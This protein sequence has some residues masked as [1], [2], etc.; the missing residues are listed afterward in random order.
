MGSQA[1][2]RLSALD[3][4]DFWD[5]M[6][7]W[8][9]E[10]RKCIPKSSVTT[11]GR[12]YFCGI[13]TVCKDGSVKRFLIRNEKIYGEN[14]ESG[15]AIILYFEDITHFFK[16]NEYWMFFKHYTDKGII[17]QFQ[18]ASGIHNSLI[19]ERE[20]DVLK[21]IAAGKTSK[22]VAEILYISPETVSQHR[23]NMLK[24]TNAK[25]TSAL[26]HFCKVCEIF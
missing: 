15:V 7:K 1:Y 14:L 24:R 2:F 23:K 12:E 18:N 6:M 8:G 26:I 10:S 20:K 25:D 19:T 5:N 22:E 9:L 4:P 3:Q 21:L 13:S 11:K 17:S 16:G